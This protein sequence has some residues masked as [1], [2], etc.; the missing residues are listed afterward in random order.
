[1]SDKR[2]GDGFDSILASR[3]VF[4]TAAEVGRAAGISPD[5]IRV[6]ARNNP[7]ALGFPVTVVGSRVYIPRV[8]FLKHCGLE[9]ENESI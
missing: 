4:L 8:P 5:H 2:K 9:G 7:A 1:M 3:A 6:Q